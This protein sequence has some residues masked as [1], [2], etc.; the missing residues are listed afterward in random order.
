MKKRIRII[1]LITAVIL[2][3]LA[4]T[5][6]VILIR[7]RDG[8]EETEAERVIADTEN[9]IGSIP[10]ISQDEN[11]DIREEKAEI[12]LDIENIPRDTDPSVKNCEIE[13]GRKETEKIDNRE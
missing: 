11:A 7:D 5:S 4:I 13:Y 6:A 1:S 8:T 2:L 10:P 3:V 9:S 12:E